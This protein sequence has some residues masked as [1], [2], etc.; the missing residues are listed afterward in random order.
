MCM[1]AHVCQCLCWCHAAMHCASPPV[2]FSTNVNITNKYRAWSCKPENCTMKINMRGRLMELFCHVSDYAS[3][4]GWWTPIYRNIW[5]VT[6]REQLWEGRDMQRGQ[7]SHLRAWRNQKQKGK[8]GKGEKKRGDAEDSWE[9]NVAPHVREKQRDKHLKNK[10]VPFEVIWEKW[11]HKLIT[12]RENLGERT[13]RERKINTSLMNEW[14]ICC[15]FQL[16]FDSKFMQIFM[17]F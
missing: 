13:E 6:G 7:E 16:L 9:R 5:N 1:C 15:Q 2:C 11:K 8:D 12:K 3:A 4:S 10:R 17:V 14:K